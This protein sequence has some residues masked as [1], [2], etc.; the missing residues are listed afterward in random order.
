VE[1]DV[2]ESKDGHVVVIH[3]EKVDRTTNGRGYVKELTLDELKQ[4]DAGLGEKIPTLREVIRE[5]KGKIRLVIEIKVQNIEQKVLQLIAE[6]TM[7]KD[8]IVVSFYSNVLEKIKG[9]D[10]EIKTGFIFSKILQS[11]LQLAVTFKSNIILPRYSL[12]SE[13]MVNDAHKLG[14]MIIPWTVDDIS[15]AKQLIK[16]GVN[17]I[18]TNKP[19]IRNE[20]LK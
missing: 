13:A 12:V 14:L 16:L 15:I 6:E 4:L 11:P 1:V 19:D 9:L 10:G 7:K 8:V 3:D 18:A 17:G 20:L 2:R 5:V